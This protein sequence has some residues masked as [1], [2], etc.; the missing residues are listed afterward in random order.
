MTA[1]LIG[2]AVLLAL[3]VASWQPARAQAPGLAEA[4]AGAGEAEESATD[5]AIAGALDRMEAFFA[6]DRA[7]AAA[8]TPVSRA[9]EEALREALGALVAAAEAEGMDEV[10]VERIL[11]YHATKRFGR[12][13]PELLRDAR[14]RLDVR[15]LLLGTGAL[16]AAPRRDAERDYLSAIAAEVYGDVLAYRRIYVANRDVISN[17]NLLTPG[18]EL[19]IPR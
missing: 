15:T 13:V 6:E 12:A 5:A 3:A 14:G 10:R 9:T 11:A 1:R 19:R 18:L 7:A 16:T 4:L 2:G 17:P 8:G